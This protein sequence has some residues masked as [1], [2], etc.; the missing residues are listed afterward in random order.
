M[1]YFFRT[2]LLSG[3][4]S[5]VFQLIFFLGVLLVGVAYLASMFSPRQPQTVALDVGLSGLRI[6]L[7]LLGLLWVQEL[8]SREV[9]QKNVILNLAYPVDRACYVLGRF[10]GIAVLLALT[11]LIISLLLWLA[12]SLSGSDYPAARQVALGWPYLLTVFG[13][14]VD[15]LV[16]TA[17]ALC[18]ATLSTVMMLPLAVGG[19]FAIAGKSLGAVIDFLLVR[20][21]DGDGEIVSRFGPVIEVL[22]WVL[23]DLSRLDWRDWPL[24]QLPP[25]GGAIMWAL[26]MALS[27]AMLFLWV[28]I[29][30]F[31]R[32]EFS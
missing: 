7:V 31:R 19:I 8:F 30:V 17:F 6:T 21:G 11:A 20:Q 29:G 14:Y 16:V 15:A 26:L 28:G 12:V 10:F 3:I 5:R 27:F 24:Y 4:R 9:E 23:P 1:G 18:L 22:R 32:R 2:T 25:T 13:L